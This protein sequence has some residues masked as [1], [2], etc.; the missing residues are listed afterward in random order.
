MYKLIVLT[1]PDSAYGFR[2]S[3][4]DV[5]EAG[6]LEAAKKALVSLVND[7]DSGIIAVNENFMAA[8]DEHTKEKINK[9]YRPIVIS[10]PAPKTV[11]AQEQ[12]LT[13]LSKLIRRAIGFEIKLGQ[14]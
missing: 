6:S 10:I 11:D 5:V 4:V 9:L 7:D 14:G 8:V 3:G 1:D 12:R 13:Y 2:L